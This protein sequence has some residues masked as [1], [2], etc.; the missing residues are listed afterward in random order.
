MIINRRYPQNL[1]G[2]NRQNEGRP[3]FTLRISKSALVNM[4]Y[5]NEIQT[6]E[7]SDLLLVMKDQTEIKVS[8][9][10]KSNLEKYI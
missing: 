9:N 5:V 8:R 6:D 3:D 1:G 4:E 2:A 7:R 10:Y